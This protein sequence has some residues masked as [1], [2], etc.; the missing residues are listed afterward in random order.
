MSLDFAHIEKTSLLDFPGEVASTLFT[1]GCNFRCPFCYN[2]SLVIPEEFPTLRISPEQAISELAKRK[3]L[4][5][6][7]CI[8]GGEPTIHGELPWFISTLRKEGIKVKLDTN[9][10]NPEMLREL[11][12]K[13][14]LD[15]VAM[16]IKSSLGEYDSASGVET[17]ISKIK[18][19]T[20]IIRAS[21]IPY[22]F[23]TTVVPGLHDLEKIEG[24]G[25]WLEGA[26]LYTIQ[27]FTPQGGSLINKEYASK[28]PFGDAELQAFENA[29]K[30]YFKKVFLRKYY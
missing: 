6:A 12:S 25:K 26:E 28:K 10:T 4:V 7:V 1:V 19:S 11:Y 15:Y 30:P 8:T 20:S 27:P 22:E 17:D 14:L 18:D 9:G 5:S 2:R 24:I 13:E 3:K 29:A 21:G 16:D 23:R